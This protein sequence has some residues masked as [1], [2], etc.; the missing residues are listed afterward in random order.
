MNHIE[1]Y[2][3]ILKR[4]NQSSCKFSAQAGTG[5]VKLSIS[6]LLPFR[7]QSV[8]VSGAMSR[9]PAN[10]QERGELGDWPA[11]AVAA[12]EEIIQSLLIGIRQS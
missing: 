6:D 11:P 4:F 8:V 2:N 12:N 9:Q 7:D 5:V 3:D 10:S 1:L